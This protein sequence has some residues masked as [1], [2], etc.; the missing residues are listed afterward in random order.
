MK[1]A[2]SYGNVDAPI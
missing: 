1:I 2:H